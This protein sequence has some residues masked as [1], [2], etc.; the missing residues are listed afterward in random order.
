MKNIKN[1]INLAIELLSSVPLD[2]EYKIWIPNCIECLQFALDNEELLKEKPE[3]YNDMLHTLELLYLWIIDKE[4][5]A[6]IELREKFKT[7]FTSE[8]VGS[9]IKNILARMQKTNSNQNPINGGMCDL[10]KLKNS[11][12]DFRGVFDILEELSEAWNLD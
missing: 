8:E 11:D 4:D 5:W 9:S 10:I 3:L 6:Y 1:Q 7:I 2:Y 12:G